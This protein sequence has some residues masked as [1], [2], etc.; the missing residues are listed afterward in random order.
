MK[1]RFGL[2]AVFVAVLAVGLFSFT[3]CEN[4]NIFGGLHDRGDSGEPEDLINDAD[5]ALRNGEYSQALSLYTQVLAVEPNNSQALYGASAAQLGTAGLNVGAIIRNVLKE[6]VGAGSIS[7]LSDMIQ[8]SRIG[9]LSGYTSNPN[10]ILYGIDLES[11]NDVLDSAICRLQKIVSGASDGKISRNDVDVLFNMG[12]L[13]VIRAAVRPIQAV[14]VDITNTNG[15]YAI[16]DM[17]GNDLGN[18][19]TANQNLVKEMARDIA[20]A[21]ALLNRIV[22]V[23]GLSQ[24]RLITQI[25]DDIDRA[26][27][28]VLEADQGLFF[29]AACTD[30]ITQSPPTGM[31]ITSANFR[32]YSEIFNPP[33][34]C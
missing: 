26:M 23:R 9:G 16:E 13:C 5:I 6:G 1:I 33:S 27:V 17:T 4:G 24:D 21:Y 3:A 10:S 2:P 29:P 11:L 20:S 19:C 31:G 34:G 30:L 18:F 12:I 25:R 28:I 8:Q 7:G 22:T 15:T 14:F 32:N